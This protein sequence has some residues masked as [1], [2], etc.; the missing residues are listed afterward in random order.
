MKSIQLLPK[1]FLSSKKS[2]SPIKLNQ[3]LFSP[4][5]FNASVTSLPKSSAQPSPTRKRIKSALSKYKKDTI[6]L[7]RVDEVTDKRN[8]NKLSESMQ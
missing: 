8:D 2:I 7:Q 1:P 3:N 6:L 4:K 5:N